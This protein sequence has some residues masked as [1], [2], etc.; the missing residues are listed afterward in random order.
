MNSTDQ[1]VFFGTGGLLSSACLKSLLEN[2][3]KPDLVLMQTVKDSPYPNLTELVCKEFD[4]NLLYVTSINE[5]KTIHTL[6]HGNYSL[7]IVASFA[8][9][10]KKELLQL[11]PIINVHMGV[12][13]FY[14]GA[15]TNF[16]KIMAND[17]VYGVTIHLME[18]KIDSGA[19]ILIEEQDLSMEVFAGEFFRKNYE[20]AG[21]ALLSA[22]AVYEVGNFEKTDMNHVQGKYYRKHNTDDMILDPKESVKKLYK[23]INRLQFYGNPTL[24]GL[25]LN[26][27]ELLLELNTA[28]DTFELLPIN[29]N[30]TI[31][32]NQS[33]ILLL[34]HHNAKC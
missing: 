7:G 18:E 11:F 6:K 8:E 31:L 32:K 26:S 24:N 33:G 25:R 19:T 1:F 23:K 9:I 2:G 34:R 28:I 14:R 15:Y 21:Q 5:E 29:P 30:K 13:P 20:M 12:L 16:W 3:R 4:L 10:F 22:L 17:D 27:A